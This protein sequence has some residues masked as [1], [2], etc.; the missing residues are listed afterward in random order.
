MGK[1][2]YRRFIRQRTQHSVYLLSG[3]E[4]NN[5]SWKYFIYLLILLYFQLLLS[6]IRHSYI[7]NLHLWLLIWQLCLCTYTLVQAIS[8]CIVFGKSSVPI[9]AE[10]LAIPTE[11]FRGFSQ[12]LQTKCWDSTSNQA[13]TDSFHII[14]SSSFVNH[15]TIGRYIIGLLTASLN[16][17]KIKEIYKRN[18]TSYN[19]SSL[20]LSHV[21]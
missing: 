15:S 1:F 8:F 10:A 13:T 18:E 11:V 9:L 6:F 4:C 12:S 19:Q 5:F 20:K 3:K 21:S 17:P 16:K 7:L 2:F 14:C